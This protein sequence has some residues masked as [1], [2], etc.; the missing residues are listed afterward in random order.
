MEDVT[1]YMA[2]KFRN[3]NLLINPDFKINQRGQAEY[4]YQTSGAIQYTV[5]RFRVVF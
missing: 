5:D 3:Q 2:D 4:A 1:I